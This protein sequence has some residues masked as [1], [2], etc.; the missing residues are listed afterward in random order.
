[1]KDWQEEYR[2]KLCSAREAAEFVKSGD[3]I[4]TAGFSAMPLE[5]SEAI[6]ERR[7]SLEDVAYYGCLSP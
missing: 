4:F 6:A 3:S 7:D 5:F 2:A 1:M